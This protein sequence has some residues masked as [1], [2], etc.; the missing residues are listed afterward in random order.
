MSV[1]L[2]S[3][4]FL[5]LSLCVLLFATGYED[6]KRYSVSVITVFFFSAVFFGFYVIF[7]LLTFQYALLF[8]VIS[9]ISSVLLLIV[10]KHQMANL[11]FYL[12][13]VSTAASPFIA[14]PAFLITMFWT[15]LDRSTHHAFAWSFARAFI[16]VAILSAVLLYFFLK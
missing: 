16:L 11:D 8:L 6:R 12:V 14:L 13:F 10:L 7:F 9:I 5:L 1:P 3:Y 2:Y 4:L 15:A